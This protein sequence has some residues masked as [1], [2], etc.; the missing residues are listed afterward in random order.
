M[1]PSRRHDRLPFDQI[2]AKKLDAVECRESGMSNDSKSMRR[3]DFLASAASCAGAV[4]LSNVV[5]AAVPCP[6]PTLSVSGGPTVSTPCPVAPGSSG[7]PTL[8][9]GRFTS[10]CGSFCNNPVTVTLPNFSLSGNC[11]ILVV[12]STYVGVTGAPTVS[13]N[14]SSGI[15][16][17]AA[18]SFVSGG[19]RIDI[20]VG[21]NCPA[22]INQ[23]FVTHTGTNPNDTQYAVYEFYNV[24]QANALDGASNG[25]TTSGTITTTADGDL[26]FCYGLQSS[27][28]AIG[29]WTAGSGFQ[30]LNAQNYN[31]DSEAAPFAQFAI[32]ATRG[33]ITPT[34]SGFNGSCQMVA[35]ALKAA[36]A[37]TAPAPG[38]RVVSV[39]G[40]NFYGGGS[41]NSGPWVLQF[42]TRGNL[43]HLSWLSLSS[44]MTPSGLSTMS[45][46]AGNS[47]T[48]NGAVQTCPQDVSAGYVHQAKAQNAH[49]STDNLITF[50]ADTIAEFSTSHVE[51]YDIT[52][53]AAASFDRAASTSGLQK[54]SGN[55]TT[56]SLTP[57]GPNELIINTVGIDAHTLSGVV[58]AG[59]LSDIAV[60]PNFDGAG[61]RLESD[62]GFSHVYGSSAT[63]FV[64]SVQNS[65]SGGIVGVQ[66]WTS[67][68]SAY[69]PG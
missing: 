24:A 39:Q 50:S 9:Q 25:T 14:L 23:I 19:R 10:T 36:S 26:I 30:L 61:S 65:T 32:Q 16:K 41:G 51:L 29:K 44:T 1:E 49:P 66:G 28:S 67:Y 11:L 69:K 53:A 43:V 46:T 48:T 3:R 4:V 60:A 20:L 21:L 13:D 58:G 34:A 62:D 57:S 22:G 59:Y 12:T 38:I 8:I 68:S 15:W 40:Y 5:E 6:P 54:V 7:T 64:Y 17:P 42:P 27:G 45:D 52:G 55:L 18:S 31:S 35:I 2:R 33:T 56:G 47:Y 63:T 37:G